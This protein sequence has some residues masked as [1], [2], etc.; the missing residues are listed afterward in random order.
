M[1]E[2]SVYIHIPFCLSKCRYCDF[3]SIP[4]GKKASAVPD[5]YIKALC[6][7]TQRLSGALVDTVYI[8]G[9]TPSLLR[10]DQIAKLF[11][12][13]KKACK[14][15]G[16]AEITFEVNPDDV[17]V[18]LLEAL[19]AAGVNR[20]SCGLQSMNDKALKFAGRRADSSANCNALELFKKNW[21]K[22]L[23]LDFICGLPQETEKSFIEG[24]KEAISYSPSHISMYSLTVEDET[25]FGKDFAA[26]KYDYDYDFADQ[27]WL[28]GRDLLIKNK[29]L[30]Y[31]VSNFSLNGAECRHNLTYWN[32]KDY[33]GL[34]SGATGTLYEEGGQGLRQ[35]NTFDIEK[36]V[37][38]WTEKAD[39]NTAIDINDI[40]LSEKIDIE[41]SE[42]EFFMMGLR[43]MQGISNLEYQTLFN[44][45]LP[46][47]FL[48]LFEKWQQKGLC[49]KSESVIKS[50][51]EVRYALNSQ[52]ILFLNSFLLELQ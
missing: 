11:D 14:L 42:F 49:T 21:K 27:L 43:K 37:K 26:G 52:G 29:Y 4:C 18:E 47:K 24:L 7:E 2:Y 38:F 32:H 41:T 46:E 15:T 39:S 16:N 28:K 25:P 20:I 45:T 1:K 30:Q 51:R 3:F 17:K 6:N 19:E 8:G 35:T 23:S 5:N 50:G 40:Q 31:E 9:G 10:P 36:Y 22:E 48:I 34:G 13:L 12:S 33:F 44:K